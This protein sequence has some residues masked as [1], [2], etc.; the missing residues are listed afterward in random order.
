VKYFK[1]N[2][3]KESVLLLL[4]FRGTII[5]NSVSL[6]RKE[7]NLLPKEWTYSLGLIYSLELSVHFGKDSR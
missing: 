2:T 5:R 4:K 7:T 3:K 1:I 6:S